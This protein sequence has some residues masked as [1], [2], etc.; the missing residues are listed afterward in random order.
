MNHRRMKIPAAQTVL[1]LAWLALL[2]PIA[3]A[4]AA[5]ASHPAPGRGI[6]WLVSPLAGFNR[7]ELAV[8]SGPGGQQVSTETETAPMY[9]LFAMMAHPRIVINDYLF[10]T[11]PNNADVL[12]NLFYANLYGDP[13]AIL[14]WN[15]G[16][17]H[18]YHKIKPPRE[19][20]RVQVPMVKAGPIVRIK[21]WGVTIN[22][23]FSYAWERIETLRSSSKNDSYL[24]GLTVD[25]RWRMINLNV[26]YYYQDSLGDY[27][28]YN[29]VF[30]RLV[31][32][33]NRN[34][35]AMLRF[36]YMEHVVTDDTSIMVGP[37]FIF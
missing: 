35:G 14:T 32:A 23:Y 7:D 20:I 29:N 1:A 16:G 9:G 12:G 27:E 17:G 22:P 18:M 5:E 8:R 2:L 11:E 4:P 3:Q 33:F 30:A 28:D 26:K 34:F 25:W 10:Y 31:F 6:M 36:D 13:D 21:P 24:Y 15:L 19:D 37:V